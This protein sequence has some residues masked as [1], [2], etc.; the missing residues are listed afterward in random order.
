MSKSVL[1]APHF[2]DERAAFAHLETSLWPNGPTC[3][4]CGGE[5]YA[6]KGVMG[7]ALYHK[8]GSMKRPA[9]ERIGLKKCRACRAQFTVRIGTIFEDSHAPLHLW[10]QAIALLAASKK[11]ISANQLHRT[12][13]VQLKTAWF[14][15]HRI[16]EA[17]TDKGP[18]PPLGGEGRIVEADETY[19][20]KVEHPREL[21]SD[22]MPYQKKPRGPANRRPIVALV[23][24]GGK[25]RAFHV[26]EANAA[27]VGQIVRENVA[28]ESRLQTDESRLYPRVGAEFAAHETVRHAAG[29]YARGDV[30]INNAESF[31]GLFKKSM[32]A[33]YQ[34]CDEKHLHRYVNEFAF[35]FNNRKALGVS[36]QEWAENAIKGVVGKRLTYQTADRVA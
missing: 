17:M 26:A 35:R 18:L 20:G 10:L 3:P 21:R 24:R 22:G 9:Q 16:R 33:V 27:T 1:S 15:A 11:G 36:D 8:D 5:G 7:K 13:G 28:K 4:K 14:M 25:V 32:V 23:E 19:Y 12:L 2:H 34:H 6:L 30:T 29:E 31:F